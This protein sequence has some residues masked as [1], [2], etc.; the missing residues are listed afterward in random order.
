MQRPVV[1]GREQAHDEERGRQGGDLDQPPRPHDPERR[2]SKV[3]V[4]FDLSQ[5]RSHARGVGR[6]TVV[7]G[8]LA[9]IGDTVR[10]LQGRDVN[11]AADPSRRREDRV[12]D[13]DGSVFVCRSEWRRS[14]RASALKDA[15][16]D[17]SRQRGPALDAGLH[18][19]V[20]APGIAGVI[21]QNPR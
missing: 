16:A 19:L 2:G 1:G 9:A 12:G 18:L 20:G 8:E 4:Q 5:R 3:A 17:G 7:S 13:S 14:L 15:P 21:H 11:C 10:C 6:I